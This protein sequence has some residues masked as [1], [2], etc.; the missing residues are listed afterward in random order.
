M[1]DQ[2]ADCRPREALNKKI[3]AEV[4]I[5]ADYTKFLFNLF[6]LSAGGTGALVVQGKPFVFIYFGVAIS[7]FILIFTAILT[8]ARIRR[9]KQY[10]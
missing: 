4:A 8:L 7:F 2:E 6:V 10:E 1:S 3:D 9:I 5:L